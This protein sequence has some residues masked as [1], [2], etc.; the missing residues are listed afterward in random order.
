MFETFRKIPLRSNSHFEWPHVLSDINCRQIERQ[1]IQTPAG[2]RFVVRCK[3][4]M[5][6]LK[7][8]ARLWYIETDLH[9]L[10]LG[11]ENGLRHRDHPGMHRQLDEAAD[12]LGMH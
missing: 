2:D 4:S 5:P 12:A 1:R 10:V 11:A 8:G 3:I 6:R 9:D 7:H